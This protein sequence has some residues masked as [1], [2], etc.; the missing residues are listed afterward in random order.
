MHVSLFIRSML[1]CGDKMK[2]LYVAQAVKNYANANSY[3]T[4]TGGSM[5]LRFIEHTYDEHLYKVSKCYKKKQNILLFFFLREMSNVE[6][7]PPPN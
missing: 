4:V 2:N 6:N 1:C 3:P 7:N 5:Y